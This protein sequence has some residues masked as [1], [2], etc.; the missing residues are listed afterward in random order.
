MQFRRSPFTW[1][2]LL[3]MLVIVLVS[4][5]LAAPIY[6]PDTQGRVTAF[7]ITILFL[8]YFR[9]VGS[10]LP[11]EKPAEPIRVTK[12]ERM[13]FSDAPWPQNRFEEVVA[14]GSK[15]QWY[16]LIQAPTEKEVRRAIK[17]DAHITFRAQRLHNLEGTWGPVE[18]VFMYPDSFY[19]REGRFCADGFLCR[20]E[21][22]PGT[23]TGYFGW[24]M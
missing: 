12:Q 16:R 22:L 7:L 18:E 9:P 11:E 13:Y 1:N 23:N 15:D 14:N 24:S 3:A 4:M 2:G 21:W 5:V 20:M 10:R 6:D 19:M 17:K 8:I